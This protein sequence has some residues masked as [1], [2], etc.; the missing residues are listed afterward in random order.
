MALR[1][2]CQSMKECMD[3]IAQDLEKAQEG[4]K[5]AAQRVRINTIKFEKAAK[6]YR[7]ES[8]KAQK[9]GGGA[10]KTSA[11][12]RAPS[13]TKKTKT[14]K[15]PAPASSTKRTTKKAAAKPKA[16]TRKRATAKLPKKRVQKR[17]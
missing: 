6:L 2:T 11:G 5:A 1:D 7:K 17:R 12:S 16:L 13:K 9:G 15:R 4:N 14:S 3:M 10:S 8:V